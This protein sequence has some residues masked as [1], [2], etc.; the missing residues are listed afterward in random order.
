MVNRWVYASLLLLLT[1][2]GAASDDH[3]ISVRPGF[4][5][6]EE[7]LQLEPSE[8]AL[9]AMGLVDGIYLAPMFGA[10]SEGSRLSSLQ[11]CV[12]GMST[13]QVAAIITKFAKEHPDKWNMPSNVL[14]FQALRVVCP[15]PPPG[16]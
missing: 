15:A 9:Y 4:S 1:A 3:V 8:Q 6:T 11:K 13:T 2:N 14:A 7:Y 10:P 16:Q 5:K 12:L